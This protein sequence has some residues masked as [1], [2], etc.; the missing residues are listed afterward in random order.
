M[1]NGYS[2]ELDEMF[3]LADML[4]LPSKSQTIKSHIKLDYQNYLR[5][6]KRRQANTN[7]IAVLWNENDGNKI[8]GCV[9]C[10]S[11]IEKL[12]GM[13]FHNYVSM[14]DEDVKYLREHVKPVPFWCSIFR[15]HIVNE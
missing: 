1:N 11:Y 15:R 4:Y 5:D 9:S 13:A 14:T 12:L 6:E 7:K 2:Y 10:P 3:A 8:N